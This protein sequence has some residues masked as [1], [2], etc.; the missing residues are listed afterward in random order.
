MNQASIIKELRL[1]FQDPGYEPTSKTE[2]GRRLK[3]PVKHRRALTT[4]IGELVSEGQVFYGKRGRLTVTQGA[5]P[6]TAPKDRAPREQ[7]SKRGEPEKGSRKT[8]GPSLSSQPARI[9]PEVEPEEWTPGADSSKENPS[10]SKLKSTAKPKPKPKQKQKSKVTSVNSREA[11]K[12]KQEPK[13]SRVK[14]ERPGPAPEKTPSRP[15]R[16][17]PEKSKSKSK[18]ES[19][20]KSSSASSG[21]STKASTSKDSSR[22]AGVTLEGVFTFDSR[23]MGSVL[24]EGDDPTSAVPVFSRDTKNAL[25]GDRVSVLLEADV[26][27]EWMQRKGRTARGGNGIRGKI[28]K[29]LDRSGRPLIGT[30]HRS[31]KFRYA[32]IEGA[33][34]PPT[35]DLPEG[36]AARRKKSSNPAKGAPTEPEEGDKVLVAVDEWKFK[37]KPPKGKVVEVLGAPDAPGVDI[38]SIV[39]RLGLATSFPEEVVAE[40]KAIPAQIPESVISERV[41]WR[42]RLVITIDPETAKDFDDAISVTAQPDGTWE[43]GVHIADV[44]HYVKPGTALDREAFA[45]GNSTYLA[46]RV[47]PMLP[48]VISN[49][50]CSLV[51]N[52]DR[53]TRC[54]V[55][56]FDAKGRRIKARFE[57]AVIRSAKRYTY[58]EALAILEDPEA[59]ESDDPR[60]AVVHEAWRL[61]AI[62]R[63]ARFKKGALALEFPEV[64][65]VLD[66][67]GRAVGIS[68]AENDISHQLI[69]EYML[70]ANEAVAL[71]LKR[72]NVPAIYRVHEDPDPEKLAEMR[73]FLAAYGIQSG[74]LTQRREVQKAL[75]AAEGLMEQDA[76]SVALLRSLKRA[77]YRA[78]P[79]GHYGLATTD[80]THFTSPIRRYADLIVHRVLFPEK[81]VRTPD[82]A[83]MQEVGR[84]ISGTERV[85]TDA[86]RE[87]QKM[88][89]MEYFLTILEKDPNRAFEA[90]VSEAQRMGVFVELDET[91]FRGLIPA[92]NLPDDFGRFDPGRREYVGRNRGGEQRVLASGIRVKVRVAKVDAELHRLDFEL[93]SVEPSKTGPL[94][95]KSPPKRK[96]S[97]QGRKSDQSGSSQRTDSKKVSR[98]KEKPRAK[99]APRSKQEPGSKQKSSPK[100]TSRGSRPPKGR[101][102]K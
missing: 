16:S 75:E 24:P 68:K 45:R 53:L 81:G 63:K 17:N 36:P 94:P 54:A 89:Q 7:K 101:R 35:V 19:K 57:K 97:D 2:L 56:T 48:E 47:L 42:D 79:L 13:K 41:D 3:V 70:A 50:L 84:H 87:S 73:E 51:P 15:D 52:E 64:R 82:Y 85:S 25:P 72:R 59:A 28:V 100:R 60:V 55:M 29:V 22:K 38:M 6:Q 90:K 37:T 46:D 62:L 61:A 86:E 67:R 69:E 98:S 4:A 23:G 31:G 93:V 34:L 83:G 102:R 5:T 21:K 65:A 88:K 74:D 1:I 96:K 18:S 30:Y 66:D 33:G 14:S 40:A 10:R 20:S 92:Q 80:Y 27:P 58:E 76:I 49:G 77:D 12:A 71:E 99:Q 9:E 43:V 32:K 39:H 44:S 8:K 26:Q 91:L 95:V 78:D 11:K